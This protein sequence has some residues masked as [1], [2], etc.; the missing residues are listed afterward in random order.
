ELGDA[1]FQSLHA[2]SELAHVI[3]AVPR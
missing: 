1:G 3:S 2:L